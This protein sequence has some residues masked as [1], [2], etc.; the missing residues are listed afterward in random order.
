V[1]PTTTNPTTTTTTTTAAATT[2]ITAMFNNLDVEIGSGSVTRV[3]THIEQPSEAKTIVA[4]NLQGENQ[5]VDLA[6][7]SFDPFLGVSRIS[8]VTIGSFLGDGAFGQVYKGN[9][10]DKQVA[11]KKIDVNYAAGNLKIT[12]EEIFESLQWEVSRLSTVSHPNLVQFYG[13]YQDP[14]DKCIYLVMEFCEGGTLQSKLEKD[15]VPYSVRWQWALELAEGLAYLHDQ[16][17]LHRDLKAENVLLDKNGR[18]KLAD[19]GVAQVDALVQDTE[20]YVVAKGMHDL[21]FIAPENFTVEGQPDNRRISTKAT[22]IYALG[23]VFWQIAS[24]G[25]IPRKERELSFEERTYLYEG[26]QIEK[27]QIPD[28]CP[29]AFKRLILACW[30]REPSERPSAQ[31]LIGRLE[32]LGAEFN[33]QHHV[34]IKA[35][36]QLEKIIHPKRKEGLSY[37]TPFIT[38]REVEES[39]EN[40][41]DKWEVAK[42]NKDGPNP[43]LQLEDTFRNFIKAPGCSTL[44]LLGEAGLGKT[45]TT[46]LWADKLMQQWWA[47]IKDL[48][49]E[50]PP[51]LPVF[52][53]PTLSDWTRTALEGSFLK[54]LKQYGLKDIPVLVFIDG[55]DEI[56]MDGSPAN[57]IKHLG[58]SGYPNAKLIVTCRPN[59]VKPENLYGCF[60]FNDELQV[61]HFLPFSL[62]QLLGYLKEQL[63]WEAETLVEYKRTLQSSKSVR[64]VL[65]NPFVLYLLK[66]SW[67][68]LSQE[69]L[70]TLTRWKIYEGFVKHSITTQCLLLTS[71]LQDTLTTGYLNFVDSFQTFA[72]DV[73]FK[74][75][76][77]VNITLN[78]QEAA[79]KLNYPWVKLK[80]LVE[81]DARKQFAKREETLSKANEEE[82]S[83]KRRR[84]LINEANFIAMMQRRRQQ[85]ESDLPLKIRNDSYEF[86]HK[87]L[88]EY[89]VAKKLLQFCNKE[90]SLILE[91]D[92]YSLTRRLA[93]SVSDFGTLLF[94]YE[95]WKEELEKHLK[96]PSMLKAYNEDENLE[97]ALINIT[98]LLDAIGDVLKDKSNNYAQAL[99]Y[100]FKTL[101][102]RE[103]VL[104]KDHPKVADSY[105][106]IGNVLNS[107]SKYEEALE[108]YFKTLAIREKVLG[109]DHPNVA[110]AYNN[111]GN[112]LFN[113]GK[114]EEALEYHF[115][116][117][118]ILEKVLG[119]DHPNVADSYNNIGNVL[120]S[121]SKYEEALEYYFKTLAIREKVLGKDH[122]KVGV[123]YNNIGT[124]LDNQGKYEKVLEYHFKALAI[125]EK[126]LGKEHPD[127]A[128]SYN[129]IG[130]VLN[131]QS[132]YEEA[133]E[134]HF[135]ALAIREKVLGKDH[136]DV[137]VAYNNIGNVLNSQSKYEE[138]LEYYFKT[139]AIR[140][141][142]LGK[143]H[144]DV[145]V[146]YNNI[147]T[148]LDNQGK[149]EKALEYHFKALA[150]REKVLS[151]DH[152]NVADSYNNIGGVL[153]KQSKYE[154][155]LEYHFKALAIKEKVLSKDHPDVA[156]VY[157]NIGSVL[158]SQSKYEEALEYYFK[159]LAI[160]EK[161]LDKDHP[162]VADTYNDIGTVL[163]SQS[164]YEE[165]LEYHFKALTI[166]EKVLSKDH[167]KVAD[168]YNNI[169]SV[170][171]NQSKYEKA[172]EYYFKTLAIRE[173]VLS[174]DH[175]NVADAYNNIGNVLFNQGKYEE[176]LEYHFKALAIKE[177]VLSKDHPK[178][179]VVYN[180]I[181]NVLFN[182][183]KYE[184]AL[185]YYFKTLAI[186][187]KVL[188]KDH[189]NI[190]DSYNNIGVLFQSQGKYGESLE[191]SLKALAIREKVL[192]KDHPNVADSYNSIGVALQTQGKYGESLEYFLKAL[193]IRE[194]V[195]GKGHPN[196]ADSYNNIGLALQF[197][198]K[199]EESLEYS[200]KALAILEQVHGKNHPNLAAPY[201]SIGV[202]FQ[203]QGKYEEG[204]EYF[205]KTLAIL[206]QVLGKDHPDV[207]TFYNNI[208]LVLQIQGKYEEGLEYFLKALAIFEQVHGKDHPNLADS[209]NN[210]G[211]VLQSQGKYEEGLEYYFKALAIK[212][213]TYGKDHQ[214]TV[215]YMQNTASIFFEKTNKAYQ[216]GDLS[217]A[218]SCY[219]I[220]DKIYS[221]NVANIKH[222]LACMYYIKALQEKDQGQE[223]EYFEYLD[224]VRTTFEAIFNFLRKE[225]IEANTYTGYALFL[226]NYHNKASKKE[227]EK[228]Q[229]LL[230]QAIERNDNSV[231]VYNKLARSITVK[232]L[233]D[234]IDKQGEVQ[235]KPKPL[236]YYL[237]IN[238]YS[239]HY[240]EGDMGKTFEQF[241]SYGCSLKDQEELVIVQY[242]LDNAREFV[243]KVHSPEHQDTVNCMQDVKP[244]EQQDIKY[245]HDQLFPS[246]LRQ[247]T[248]MVENPNTSWIVGEE[249]RTD[250]KEKSFRSDGAKKLH[251]EEHNEIYKSTKP[252]SLIQ[253]H[254]LSQGY[255]LSEDRE[256]KIELNEKRW[257]L[258]S[259]KDRKEKEC[260]DN[261]CVII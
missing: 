33:P 144:P 242:L 143:D 164:K 61:C 196:V 165:A 232:P 8:S 101:A 78:L 131:S 83:Q 160:K 150:I 85:F 63:S 134:Y 2:N 18:A 135:K 87:S 162:N 125:L 215:S 230:I 185:E 19:L 243:K 251:I 9:W 49:I 151:K 212:E 129:N 157:N 11:L 23:L 67:K 181:G 179:A 132:K 166:K 123:A 46:Y 217:T 155:A 219:E 255:L 45:L 245:R 139:L 102:I 198:G 93:D 30:K 27:E 71:Q 258:H 235:I 6:N 114:Y 152:P 5:P 205:L 55:Y 199:Y 38:T 76:Q 58:L 37:I 180:N 138:A 153:H 96:I 167:P 223:K 197:Q 21:H 161:V 74:A 116:A 156:V 25:Q 237:L 73:A 60:N 259:D 22:D 203:T 147:G 208:G 154:E 118:A 182:Q 94:L 72:R 82:K 17:I 211:T 115:K 244:L 194:K 248:V 100:Y 149:Y 200:L 86:S 110:V 91:E 178:V 130:S 253:Y 224:K 10:G 79:A 163:N 226:L 183:G 15:N 169:G 120:N 81:E 117:L 113:Q 216:A 70:D 241:E 89:F 173:K 136:P 171:N 4:R 80:E 172:L 141:K 158:N 54:I 62:E 184:E 28:D 97:R 48:S 256:Q 148:I 174:K 41:W 121:Q 229:N 252:K 221:Q 1:N 95:G 231:L 234:L 47:Y 177:K 20:A 39:I 214:N 247:A 7:T 92:L 88:F 32:R 249:S 186:R 260:C 119:K 36:N 105:N 187:E 59:T 220:L 107:Q 192:G 56:Q 98:I 159:T 250:T 201:T 202:L 104:G 190:A 133:L 65:R 14:K 176:A 225:V 66:Q 109:K 52:I 188:S 228:I 170:L 175:P 213:K 122:P 218:I 64:E 90:A 75:C 99:D 222:N 112:V 44:L 40:Y 239:I 207:A 42:E 12:E 35:C 124:I 168:A 210:I 137:A 227:Y 57:L 257:L 77:N 13:I 16:G 24:K 240:E 140:E 29:K 193:A 51:Y 206:E 106:N 145:A 246:N 3:P 126:V 191:Y 68:T 195:L 233:Q 69:P 254:L 31:D 128:S 43:P 53:R 236:A 26:Q 209:Y 84:V 189:P 261:C 238:L 146:A 142:V 111:I 204:F 34:L 127:V 103:K 50:R 108:Y